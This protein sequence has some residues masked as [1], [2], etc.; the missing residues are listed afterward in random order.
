MQLVEMQAELSD[1]GRR[2]VSGELAAV[3]A[4]EL[5][6]PLTAVV[7]YARSAQLMWQRSSDPALIDE[8]LSKASTQA[9]RAA[10]IVSRLRNFIGQG[11]HSPVAF[12]IGDLVTEVIKLTASTAK[13]GGIVVRTELV[14][15]PDKVYA[16]RVQISQVIDNLIRNAIDAMSENGRRPRI[17]TVKSANDDTGDVTVR[18]TDTGAGI[19]ADLADRI[20]LP[21]ITSKK[22]GMGLGLAICKTII[23]AHE[24]RLWYESVQGGGSAFAFSLHPYV[25]SSDSES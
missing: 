6:Q 10:E 11:V 3:I 22:Q 13:A 17:L 7:Y 9:N 18:I 2:A 20:F 21:F 25:D 23:S 8:T 24:G 19:A 12:S 16:D 15:A 1:V 4:H 14:A 5:N